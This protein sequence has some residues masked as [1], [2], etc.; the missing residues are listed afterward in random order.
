MDLKASKGKYLSIFDKQKY[1]YQAEE[2][3]RLIYHICC[4]SLKKFL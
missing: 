4:K 2:V 1:Y 3:R